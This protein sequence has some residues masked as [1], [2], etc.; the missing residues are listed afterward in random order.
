LAFE[1]YPFVREDFSG[2]RCFV[3][4]ATGV[5]MTETVNPSTGEKAWQCSDTDFCAQHRA[6]A[7]KE[8]A[9]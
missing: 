1:D 8:D 3:C 7:K 6:A 4:G 9:R 5:F 2:K